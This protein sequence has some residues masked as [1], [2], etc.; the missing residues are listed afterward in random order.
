MKFNFLQ[1]NKI[2]KLFKSG[3]TEIEKKNYKEAINYFNQI[4]EIDNTNSQALFRKGFCYKLL[5]DYSNAIDNFS[6]AIA[7]NPLSTSYKIQRAITFFLNHNY[8]L[9][10]NEFNEIFEK[11]SLS[12]LTNEF[13]FIFYYRSYTFYKLNQFEK[14]FSEEM[15]DL[16]RVDSQWT[17]PENSLK[18]IEEYIKLKPDD[19]EGYNLR[20][21][22]LQ[23]LNDN[24]KA[25][26]DFDKSIQINSNFSE[27]YF[28]RA[29]SNIN[30][31]LINEAESDL[32]QVIKLDP[33]FVKAYYF[34]GKIYFQTQNFQNS[35]NYIN[36]ALKLDDNYINAYF[37]RA[38]VFTLQNE[39]EKAI[40]DYNN[41]LKLNDS[42]F[43]IYLLKS[44][45][46]KKLG[47][48]EEAKK[49]LESSF[50]YSKNPEIYIE[51]SNIEREN[52]NY[53][54]A[55]SIL[56]DGMEFNPNDEKLF[57]EKGKLNYLLKNYSEAI[58]DFN[59]A[60]EINPT[61]FK[62]YYYRGKVKEQ[63]YDFDGAINDYS[64][65]LNDANF[66]EGYRARAN[67]RMKSKELN[68][69]SIDYSKILS[70]N[71]ADIDAYLNKTLCLIN[72]NK[73]D[74]G[75][76]EINRCIYNFPENGNAYFLRALINYNLYQYKNALIDCENALKMNCTLFSKQAN[77][78]L[79]TLQKKF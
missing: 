73:Y 59:M 14:S 27:A 15:S 79:K 20:G 57:I 51:I 19:Y 58:I 40:N 52:K 21:L 61:N 29:I 5:G 45:V 16:K 74:D 32:F 9:A 76:K 37:L 7:I 70:L 35:L 49:I 8:E 31:N 11:N 78:L 38:Q 39:F 4:L 34:L 66:I 22:I 65:S 46:L 23:S 75:L 6:K 71:N 17:P 47:K 33:N 48:N 1:K 69:A 10:L 60:L 50:K 55:I 68:A 77:D 24:K 41:I 2:E 18:D 44:K 64:K 25:I 26:I 36:Q 13:P 62:I 54:K 42:D 53:E 56:K 72:L 63:L 43:K 3:L 28:N 12:Y 67:L 30:L